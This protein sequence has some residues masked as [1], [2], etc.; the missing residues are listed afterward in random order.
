MKKIEFAISIG[1]N[2]THIYKAGVG[3]VLSDKSVV[4]TGIKGK[5]E[6]A[7]A[8]GIDAVTSGIDYR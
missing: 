4:V 2:V 6:I 3:V 8:V 1:S 7:L 5:K